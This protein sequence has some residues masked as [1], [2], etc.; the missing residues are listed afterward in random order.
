MRAYKNAAQCLTDFESVFQGRHANQADADRYRYFTDMVG[1][2]WVTY[3]KW[4]D[5]GFWEGM[6]L[7]SGPK[8]VRRQGGKQVVADGVVFPILAALSNFVVKEE[9]SWTFRVPQVFSDEYLKDAARRQLTQHG[10]KPM[11]MGR[12]GAAYEGLMLVTE[13]AQKYSQAAA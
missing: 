6:Y 8:Q 13:M 9:G 4:R 5:A 10:G 12:S 11:L 7:R 2:A 1:L 3:D